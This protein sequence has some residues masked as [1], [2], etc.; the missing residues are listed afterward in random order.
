MLPVVLGAKALSLFFFRLHD[1]TY[2]IGGGFMILLAFLSLLGIKLPMISLRRK[3]GQ[4]DVWSTFTLGIF[5]GI[6]SSCCAPVLIGVIALSSLSP[7]LL[8]SLGVGIFYVLGM[9]APLYLASVLIDTKNILNRPLLR[10]NLAAVKLFGR[11]F[12][13][14]TTNAIAFVV[15]LITGVA[16]ISLTKMGLLGMD[17]VNSQTT[18][19]IQR[20]AWTI[21][22]WSRKIQ[23]INLL[24]VIVIGAVI[25]SLI[26]VA[27]NNSKLKTQNSKR[28]SKS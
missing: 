23:F 15:F 18:K 27:V 6:T 3:N 11:Q 26:R 8:T 7:T 28:K 9:V 21:T 17:L 4:V 24:F 14:L 22:D 2:Y 19:T 1:Q 16:T 10:K 25:Y 5:S 20:V 12:D 13:I